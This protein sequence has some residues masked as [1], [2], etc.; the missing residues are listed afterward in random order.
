MRRARIFVLGSYVNA[1]CLRV[2]RLPVPGESLLSTG[3]LQEPGGK[4]L[5]LAVGAHRLGAQVDV[6]IPAGDD[7][8]GDALARVLAAEG[9]STRDLLR[10][11]V[12]SGRGVGLIDP[13]GENV[14]AVW[15]GANAYLA[16]EH[17]RACAQRIEAAAIVC[18]QFELDDVPIAAAF[19]IARR[20]GIRTLLNM[21][22]FRPLPACLA[23]RVDV[24]VL[25]ASEAAR[26]LDDGRDTPFT[27]ARV[28]ERL[29]QCSVLPA[30]TAAVVTLGAQGA[31]ARDADGNCY[32]QPGF[33]VV[34]RDATG[35]GDAFCAGLATALAEGLEWP[36]SLRRA[37]ACGAWVAQHEGVLAGLPVRADVQAMLAGAGDARGG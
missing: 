10:L 5:N 4:G 30:H 20:G 36:D 9:M 16:A 32:V 37:T 23:G 22:P 24:L 25:N 11:P 6:L 7:A 3:C 28:L 34:A 33:S 29:A 13:S 8:D 1:T 31:V 15:R 18:A 21:A 17:V 2:E 27:P 14:I 35:A 19:D 26:W 12:S